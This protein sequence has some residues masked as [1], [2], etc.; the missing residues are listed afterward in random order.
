MPEKSGYHGEKKTLNTAVIF[1]Y[2]ILK[3]NS[4]I[5]SQHFDKHPEYDTFSVELCVL[6]KPPSLFPLNI[7]DF[8]AGALSERDYSSWTW[9]IASNFRQNDSQC[10]TSVTFQVF[11]CCLEYI[12]RDLWC[13]HTVCMVWGPE[14]C[15]GRQVYPS[16]LVGS[17]NTQLLHTQPHLNTKLDKTT[18]YWTD[19]SE[20]VYCM[21]VSY[22]M[23]LTL[24]VH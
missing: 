19:L 3:N 7:S 14:L 13:T 24:S 1:K 5:N 23:W 2:S 8:M 16:S 20:C 9:V 6:K 10:C 17:L 21:Y 18:W 11:T 12:W 15:L 4:M 22:A